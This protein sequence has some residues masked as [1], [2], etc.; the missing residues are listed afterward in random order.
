MPWSCSTARPARCSSPP[1]PVTPTTS[2]ATRA[3]AAD[4]A[5]VVDAV[6][7]PAHSRAGR[8][9]GRRHRDPGPH[10]RPPR[11]ARPRA[12]RC[13][14]DPRLAAAGRH[15]PRDRRPRRP[16]RHLA[17]LAVDRHRR[18]QAPRRRPTRTCCVR[19]AIRTTRGGR[20]LSRPA[21]GEP[22]QGQYDRS[23]DA[24]GVPFAGR[25]VERDLLVDLRG[26]ETSFGDVGADLDLGWRA[27]D[28][29]R[30]V[31]VV[32]AARMRT[33]PGVASRRASTPTRRRAARRVALARAP[34][35]DRARPRRCGSRSPRSS[36]PWACCS[37]SGPARPGP[38]CRRSPRST[39]SAAPPPAGAPGT[40]A[41]WAGAT[42]GPCSSR[43]AP[44]SPG[45]GMPS[46]TR[47]SRRG[48]RSATRPTTST[49]APGWSRWC[50]TPGVL[51][52][53]GAAV[54]SVVAGRSL[55]I[56]VLTGA[57]RGSSGGELV[58][59]RADASTCSG[60]PGPT[61]GPAPVS[62]GPTR[63]DPGRPL[64]AL[65]TWLVDH[66]PLLPDPGVRRGPGRRP[67]RRLRD[68]A[69]GRERLHRPPPRGHHAL[70]A[71]AGRVRV[72]DHRRRLRL[73]GPGP[74]SG[75]S[76]PSS[77]CR[78][79]R[80]GLW[81]LATRRS[82][83]TSAFATALAARGARGVRPGAARAWSACWPSCWPWC[84]RGCARTPWSS[85][86]CPVAV[87]GAVVRSARP[88][89]RG[90]CSS[91]GAGLAQWGG[92]TPDPWQLALLNPGG[93]GAPLV[94]TAVPL[95]AVA[96]LALAAR[97]RLGQRRR[98]R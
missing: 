90:R 96:V 15:H 5:A 36:P 25:L 23:S 84:V 67:R 7:A 79:S 1:P 20:L 45:G 35:V 50:G 4:H 85:R 28:A 49:P 12:R 86:S 72:G 46:T 52:A 48:P 78:R 2:V 76:S 21:P 57:G 80:A 10:R 39:R 16:R 70:G 9:P 29:G 94:W 41:R 17:A 82:T 24:L 56:G 43:G 19:S 40:A 73:G 58:G 11:P 31:V 91:A 77:C 66:L 87:L 51:A 95:V 27:H 14:H 62:A 54:V 60:T 53:A 75:P 32:P 64:L 98:P 38:S 55:G 83:A 71:R 92:T 22:D 6:A 3:P 63:S 89:S 59:N 65:P 42:C 34:V 44:C 81:L 30:R 74:A 93:A 18:P 37:S 61:A 97:S 8:G 47:S 13:P 69:R 68:A 33:D 26:W 88:R